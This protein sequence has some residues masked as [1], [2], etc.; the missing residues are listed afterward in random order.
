MEKVRFFLKNSNIY[1]VKYQHRFLFIA[2]IFVVLELLSKLPYFNIFLTPSYL[3]GLYILILTITFK[4]SYRHLFI[5][6][7]LILLLSIIFALMFIQNVA[8]DLSNILYI[9]LLV[10]VGKM[11]VYLAKLKK[12]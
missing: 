12:K 9:L 11:F 2:F 4:I 3:I 10:G 5:A 1:F 6:G 8:E 7:S